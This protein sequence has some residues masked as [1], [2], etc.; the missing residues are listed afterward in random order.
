MEIVI[1]ASA[2]PR[3]WPEQDCRCASCSRLRTAGT[4][5]EP[6]RILVDGLPLDALSPW[7]VPGGLDM[8]SPKGARLLLAAGPGS[9]PEPV[10]DTVYDAVFL[11]LIGCPDHLGHLR[12]IGAVIPTTRV[13]AVHRD[14]RIPSEAEL[15]RRLSLWLD[16][17]PGP[18]RTLLLGGSRSGK[19]AEA[20]LRLI[21]CPDVTYLAT[22]P[23][24]SESDPEWEARVTAHKI[25]RPAWWRTLE[26]VDVAETLRT[27]RGTLLIDGFG[28]WLAAVMDRCRAWEE[29]AAVR[30]WFDDLIDAWRTTH[31]TVVAVSDEVGLSLIP[32]TT[33]GRLF[34]DLLGELNQ[35]LAAE[36][37]ETA[38]VVAG[39]IL[40]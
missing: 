37:E 3:G 4:T 16:S 33:S 15:K 13:Y 26:T 25:R 8:A 7:E 9:R 35:L 31:A 22:G 5:H 11:D 28:T 17:S 34:R 23:V 14:H 30:P 10:T 2:G 36:S 21:T 40:T 27:S 32:S 24:P 18:H 19:S 38:L 1:E 39:R 29:P 12:R 6:T 20:E